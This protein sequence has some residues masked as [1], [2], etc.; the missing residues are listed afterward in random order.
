MR[1]L[2]PLIIAIIAGLLAACTQEN[3][4][5]GI[6]EFDVPAGKYQVRTPDEW[7]ETPEV[8]GYHAVESPDLDFVFSVLS[9]DP[10][11]DVTSRF[12]NPRTYDRN[13]RSITVYDGPPD[14]PDQYFG[15]TYY[16]IQTLRA[17]VTIDG[18]RYHTVLVR[19]S[20]ASPG[21]DPEEIFIG[22]NASLEP[23]P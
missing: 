22:L 5:P 23:M 20:T 10:P 7:V 16:P 6:L 15:I 11:D 1:R 21:E 8:G 18:R 12:R 17:V 9:I 13:G 19:S 3:L 4:P 14:N 2:W